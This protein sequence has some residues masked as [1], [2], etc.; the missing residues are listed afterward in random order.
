VFFRVWWDG[1]ED[2]A[3]LTQRR[4]PAHDLRGSQHAGFRRANVAKKH[5]K[6]ARKTTL[7]LSFKKIFQFKIN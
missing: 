6:K 3:I 5:R 1:K 4:A 7:N 2:A